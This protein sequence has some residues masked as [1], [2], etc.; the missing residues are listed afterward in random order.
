MFDV[1]KDLRHT[2]KSLSLRPHESR[3]GSE[4]ILESFLVSGWK[5]DS[6]EDN[7]EKKKKKIKEN[8]RFRADKV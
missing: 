5:V 2:E 7:K 1:K 4:T 8:T 3:P 6:C